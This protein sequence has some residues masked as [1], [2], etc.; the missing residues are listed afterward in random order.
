QHSKKLPQSSLADL[1]GGPRTD[2]VNVRNYGN[3]KAILLKTDIVGY[4]Q[5]RL[6]GKEGPIHQQ[7]EELLRSN[8]VRPQFA[9]EDDKGHSVVG[10]DAHVYANGGVRIIALESNPELR[11]DELGPP[12]FRS[13][14]RFSKPV[15]V[16][17]HMPNAMYLYD[18]RAHKELGQK[19]ELTLT[20]DPYSPTILTASD[21]PLPEMQVSLPK[22]VQRGSVANIAIQAEPA[23]ADVSIFHVDVLDPKGSPV[24]YYSGNLIVQHGAGVKSIP[25]AVDDAAGKWTVVVR[26]VLSGQTVT[27]TMDVE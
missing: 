16:H 1:F 25:F 2:E 8:G 5:D 18:T 6:E 27:Q 19:K 14:A 9:V 13:N 15:T 23:Q 24:L 7:I 4:L 17:L 20:V 26:D 12:D 3:G 21:T 11:V 22:Q 10:I